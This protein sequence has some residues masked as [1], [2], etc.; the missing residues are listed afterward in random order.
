MSLFSDNQEFNR[1]KGTK[2]KSTSAERLANANLSQ[3]DSDIS[4]KMSR[5]TKP[6]ANVEPAKAKLKAKSAEYKMPKQTTPDMDTSQGTTGSR[7]SFD[8]GEFT[9]IPKNAVIA[10]ESERATPAPVEE[11]A[12]PKA[13][14]ESSRFSASNPMGMKK[15]GTVK[16]MS[17]GGSASSRG[18]GC[19]QRGKTKGRMY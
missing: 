15:G 18:D 5:D 17:A 8:E 10:V 6:R 9:Q 14:E 4:P 12:V 1:F 16:K 13:K 7:N 3:S 19:A 11:R 2:P